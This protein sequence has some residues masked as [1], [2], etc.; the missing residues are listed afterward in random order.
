MKK[1]SLLAFQQQPTWTEQVFEG[2][3]NRNYLE[4]FVKLVFRFGKDG[5]EKYF[6]P[7]MFMLYIEMMNVKNGA[8]VH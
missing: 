2:D 7:L 8:K 5:T 3:L 1:K 6:E 4:L